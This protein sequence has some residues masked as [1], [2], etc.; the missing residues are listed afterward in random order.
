M[1]ECNLKLHPEKTKLVYCRDY[2]RQE[3]HKNVKFDFLSFSFQPRTSKSPKTGK[4]FLGYGCA[5]SI[6]SCK[7]IADKLEELIED[8]KTCKSI[9]GIAQKL[10]PVIQGWVNYYVKYRLWE[11]HKV[12]RMLHNRLVRWAR[13]KYKRYKTSI[14]RGYNWLKRMK[15]Q[16]PYLFYHWKLSFSI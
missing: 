9:V 13:R 3:K 12:F 10:N 14:R 15:K 1:S 16:F 4:L 11:L 2:R 5:I 8:S 7:K 6:G